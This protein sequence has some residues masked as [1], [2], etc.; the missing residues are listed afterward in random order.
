[1]A[2]MEE[3]WRDLCL[4]MGSVSITL[5]LVLE[6]R[7]GQR[8]GRSLVTLRGRAPE[9]GLVFIGAKWIR[10]F[11]HLRLSKE[12]SKRHVCDTGLEVNYD[13][14]PSVAPTKTSGRAEPMTHRA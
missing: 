5:K 8:V 3:D 7:L 14:P 11:L 9:R 4:L 6:S 1:M 10:I 12:I 13:W 2:N